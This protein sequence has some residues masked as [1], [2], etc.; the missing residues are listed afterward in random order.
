MFFFPLVYSDE[1][2]DIYDNF[3]LKCKIT[4]QHILETEDGLAKSYSSYMN[5]MSIGDEFEIEFK[6]LVE[7]RI[8]MTRKKLK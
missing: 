3:S 4:G 6:N 7:R 5:G 1:S 2:N 8:K